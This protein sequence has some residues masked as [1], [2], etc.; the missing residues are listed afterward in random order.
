MIHQD[1]EKSAWTLG[2]NQSP[3]FASNAL[4]FKF[5]VVGCG[6]GTQIIKGY[7][8]FVINHY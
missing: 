6:A 4:K 5:V 2:W 3:N 8:G 1:K 7:Y